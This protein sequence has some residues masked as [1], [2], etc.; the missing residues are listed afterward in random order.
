MTLLYE[1]FRN[2]RVFR[3]KSRY[4]QMDVFKLHTILLLNRVKKNF[5]MQEFFGIKT[6]NLN[7]VEYWLI[8]GKED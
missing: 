7:F 1:V 4:Y 2:K 5:T 8:L 3:Q 6:K